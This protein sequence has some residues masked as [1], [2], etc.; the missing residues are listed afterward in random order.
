A[1]DGQDAWERFEA[2]DFPIVI[3][4]WMMPKIDGLELIRRIRA[5]GRPNYVYA[6]LLTAR[7]QKEHVVTGM[8][9]GAD[10]FVTKPF[11]RDE[12]RVRLREGE[13]IIRLERSLAEQN[14]ALREAQAALVQSEKLASLGQLAAGMAHEINNPL[15]FVT[16]NVAV[17]KRDVTAALAVLAKYR[18]AR[19]ALSRVEPQLAAEAAAAEEEIDL[20]YLDQ[21]VDRLFSTSLDGLERVRHIVHNLREFARLD[22]AEE[23]ELDVNAALDVTVEILQHEIKTKQIDV[24]KH[25]GSMPPLFGRAGKINQVFLN[26]ISNAIQACEVGGR[27]ELRT[28]EENGTTI[29]EIEDNGCGIPAENLPRLFEPFFTTRAVGHGMG[30]GLAISYGI[31]RDHGGTIE[32]ESQRGRG[33]TFRVRLPCALT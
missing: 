16:N 1:S 14:R 18:S 11:D 25:Y 4:D 32:V 27:V 33:S 31:V 21:N 12:L 5:A 20:A 15:A 23:K 19:E 28:R 13:R 24:Q 22:E 26:L 10:D 30:M 9:A 6:I 7:S 2:G 17:L 29:I 8:E 3:S